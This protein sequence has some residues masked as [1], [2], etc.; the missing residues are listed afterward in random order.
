MKNIIQVFHIYFNYIWFSHCKRTKWTIYLFCFAESILCCFLDDEEEM[1]NNKLTNI[2]VSYFVILST[3]LKELTRLKN[4]SFSIVFI[5]LSEN[6]SLESLAKIAKTFNKELYYTGCFVSSLVP[7][8]NSSLRNRTVVW[9]KRK[10]TIIFIVELF[11]GCIFIF[12]Y[13]WMNTTVQYKT[14]N[15]CS[16]VMNYYPLFLSWY[17]KPWK[18]LLSLKLYN[19][20]A[21]DFTLAVLNIYNFI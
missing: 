17:Q 5:P 7:E 10:K 1:C 11:L 21:L 16:V 14:L 3:E 18:H 20:N 12:I 13:F 15:L 8:T 6:V 19:K 2:K 4:R 9:W